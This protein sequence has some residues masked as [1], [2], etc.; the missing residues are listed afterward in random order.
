MSGFYGFFRLCKG[1]SFTYVHCFPSAELAQDARAEQFA[2]NNSGALRI[3][4]LHPV[5]LHV[6]QLPQE[7]EA[8]RTPPAT[9]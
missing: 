9:G 6:W 7:L 8:E 2:A 3:D 5:L 4:I 1:K